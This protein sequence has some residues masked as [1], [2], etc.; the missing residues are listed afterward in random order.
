MLH[1]LIF[2]SFNFRLLLDI[3]KYFFFKFKL[4]EIVVKLCLPLLMIN[5]ILNKVVFYIYTFTCLSNNKLNH[6]YCSV[7]F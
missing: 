1:D 5:K 4:F 2:T 6:D 7:L 3:K